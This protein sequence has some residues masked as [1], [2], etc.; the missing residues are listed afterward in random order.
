ML[1]LLIAIIS[2]T[3]ENF[4]LNRQLTDIR[5]TIRILLEFN[6]MANITKYCVKK[7]KK[8]KVKMTR[9]SKITNPQTQLSTHKIF[10]LIKKDDDVDSL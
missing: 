8:I 2:R 5:D 3:F 1:N 10:Y 9:K 6:R 7:R 4:Q